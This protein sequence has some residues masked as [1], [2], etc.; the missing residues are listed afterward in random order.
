MGLFSLEKGRL[1]GDLIVA[2]QY[3][4][5]RY[6]KEGDWLCNRVCGDRTR[7]MVSNLKRRDFRLVIRKK[8]WLSREMV[9]ALSLET[10][11][12]RLEGFC[13]PWW[14]CRCPCSL[15]GQWMTFRS[16]FQL[17]GSY[18]SI[19]MQPMNCAEVMNHSNTSDRNIITFVFFQFDESPFIL[20]TPRSS[21]RLIKL[22]V[23]WAANCRL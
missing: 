19:K 13:A 1:W 16:P 2:F 12:V 6:R 18:D 5:G 15:Q 20:W 7:E 10:A 9:D 3:L 21:W 17:E 11:K 8:S 14:S 23:L 4:K 22:I